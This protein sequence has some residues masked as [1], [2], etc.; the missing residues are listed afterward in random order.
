MQQIE[1]TRRERRRT[2]RTAAFLNIVAA[3]PTTSAGPIP[4][5]LDRGCSRSAAPRATSR[6]RRCSSSSLQRSGRKR[7]PAGRRRQRDSR[8]HKR[9]SVARLRR[10]TPSSRSAAPTERLAHAFRPSCPEVDRQRQLPALAQPRKSRVRDRTA[11]PLSGPV[12]EGVEGCSRRT[13]TRR[14]LGSSTRA[15]CRRRAR[16]RRGRRALSDD[17]PERIAG[18]AGDGG[19]RL[20]RSLDQPAARPTAAHRG[21]LRRAGATS[22]KRSSRTPRISSGSALRSGAGSSPRRSSTGPAYP[23]RRRT[24]RRRST[25]RPRHDHAA[26]R[27]DW[28]R[29]RR[30]LRAVQA[31]VRRDRPAG[32]RGAAEACRPKRTPRPQAAPGHPRRSSGPRGGVGAA[33]D[34]RPELGGPSHRAF[35]LREFGG[36]EGLE[37]PAAAHRL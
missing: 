4:A 19:R 1:Q 32:D 30:G 15:S 7:W 13:P 21:R 8:A 28:R 10:R 6:P 24:R 37:T 33:A 20:A 36:A 29:R 2:S 18:L 16:A 9:S 3:S 5:Q 25:I 14:R 17:P 22:R 35:L 26:R 31:A 23:S 34:E 12:A 11:K 27:V